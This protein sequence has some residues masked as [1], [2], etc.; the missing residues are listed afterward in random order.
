MLELVLCSSDIATDVSP[1]VLI[2]FGF[3][4]GLVYC[5]IYRSDVCIQMLLK[6]TWNRY[7]TAY[8]IFHDLPIKCLC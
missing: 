2:S 3:F 1:R 4:S 8:S 7:S 5:S 6:D